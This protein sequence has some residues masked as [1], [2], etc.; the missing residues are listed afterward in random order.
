MRRL[1]VFET[2]AYDRQT[3]AVIVD[4]S[5]NTWRTPTS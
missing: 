1:N 4:G 5:E 3:Y 2:D